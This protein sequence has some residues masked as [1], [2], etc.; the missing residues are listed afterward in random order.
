MAF[1]N[2]RLRQ[3]VAE[4]FQEKLEMATFM[5]ARDGEMDFVIQLKADK[6]YTPHSYRFTIRYN[7]TEITSITHY[8]I[9][10]HHRTISEYTKDEINEIQY[11]RN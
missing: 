4:N 5:A 10:K 8:F 11:I 1:F 2:P 3:F 7:E 6:K 9:T